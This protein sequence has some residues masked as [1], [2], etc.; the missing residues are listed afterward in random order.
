Q[1]TPTINNQFFNIY[2]FTSIKIDTPNLATHLI[3]STSYIT[4]TPNL[5]PNTSIHQFPQLFNLLKPQIS[6]LP[7]TPPLYNQYELI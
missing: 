7:P 2:N 5:I 4:N 3:H 6:I 1:E